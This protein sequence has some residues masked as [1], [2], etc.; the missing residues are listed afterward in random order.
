MQNFHD[1]FET[2][3]QSLV[4]AF[5]ICKTAPLSNFCRTLEM[6]LINCEINFIRTWSANCVINRCTNIC[7]NCY[8]TLCSSSNSVYSKQCKKTILKQ[9]K[10]GFKQKLSRYQSNVEQIS[11]N[12][13]LN[14][15][16]LCQVLQINKCFDF[17]FMLFAVMNYIV[18]E[19]CCKCNF[20]QVTQK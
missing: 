18:Y 13:Y 12:S 20:T 11:P 14:H 17:H 6:P 16:T 7:N 5:S 10:S 4:S 8:K 1:T 15:L 3:K 9:L 2:C 19:S